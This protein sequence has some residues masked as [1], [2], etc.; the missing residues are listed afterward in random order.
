M[1]NDDIAWPPLWL[2]REFQEAGEEAFERQTAFMR[3]L[4]SPGF[5]G[6]LAQLEAMSR[7]LGSFKTRVQS[8][9]RISIPD[10]EREA[11]GIR[12]GDIVQAI[13]IPIHVRG[14]PDE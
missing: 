3:R 8:G 14:D 9:G 7:S 11:L 4:L 13:V 12:E 10:A 1:S 2:A 5:D 6:G